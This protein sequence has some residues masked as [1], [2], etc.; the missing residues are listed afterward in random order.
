M[1]A[2]F[3]SDA[4]DPG[5]VARRAEQLN[6]TVRLI[7]ADHGRAAAVVADLSEVGLID[8][9]VQDASLPFGPP[10]ILVNAAGLNPRQPVNEISSDS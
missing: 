4:V 5:P 2:R 10:D 8:A 9:L 1:R 7:E 6:E 3:G